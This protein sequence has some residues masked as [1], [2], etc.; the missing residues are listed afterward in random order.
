M[1]AT[2]GTPLVMGG[3]RAKA[4]RLYSLPVRMH[5]VCATKSLCDVTVNKG[6]G[7]AIDA[8][9]ASNVL[10]QR[11]KRVAAAIRDNLRAA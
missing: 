5:E 3:K 6:A 4:L 1:E 2:T 8:N 7:S 11:N 9:K 10:G